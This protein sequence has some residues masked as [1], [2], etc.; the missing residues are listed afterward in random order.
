[1][2][3]AELAKVMAQEDAR[4]LTA[5]WLSEHQAMWVGFLEN[6]ELLSSAIHLVRSYDEGLNAA[7]VWLMLANVALSHVDG[8]SA[9]A[10]DALLSR[11]RMQTSATDG[12]D[13]S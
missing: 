10:V 8:E 1:M 11:V 7:R 13:A 4:N 2:I 6:G 9:K 12:R 3:A 5:V